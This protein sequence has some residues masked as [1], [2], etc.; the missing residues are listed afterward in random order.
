MCKTK[1]LHD[2]LKKRQLMEI[3]KMMMTLLKYENH[4][5][6][7]IQHCGFLEQFIREK[8]TTVTQLSIYTETS[9]KT[10]IFIDIFLNKI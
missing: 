8:D 6:Q 3:F 5:W 10:T 9:T 4:Y 1:E 7:R 2:F